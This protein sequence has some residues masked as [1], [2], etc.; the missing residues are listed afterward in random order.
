MNAEKNIQEFINRE[1]QIQPN[2]F[3]ST[4]IMARIE[5]PQVEIVSRWKPV[6][7]T[8]FLLLAVIMGISIG[9]SYRPA[10]DSYT[11]VSINDSDIEGLAYF[12]MNG[13]E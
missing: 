3:L 1:K 8:V 4:R 9:K 7:L 13:D 11:G 6:V 5:T 12:N 10:S 2:P